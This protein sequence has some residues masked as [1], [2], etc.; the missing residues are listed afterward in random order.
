MKTTSKTVNFWPSVADLFLCSFLLFLGLSVTFHLPVFLNYQKALAVGGGH[1]AEVVRLKEENAKLKAEN[2]KLKQQVE[3]DKRERERLF[4]NI[5]QHVFREQELKQRLQELLTQL[6][7]SEEDVRKLKTELADLR[8]AHELRLRE[9]LRQL[10]KKEED[11]LKLNMELADRVEELRLAKALLAETLKNASDAK[12]KFEGEEAQTKGQLAKVQ[13]NAE[14]ARKKFEDEERRLKEL[15]AEALK[16]SEEARK[17]F[18]REGNPTPAII[19][20]TDKAEADSGD[21]FGGFTFKSGSATLSPDFLDQMEGHHIMDKIIQGIAL[22]KS[23]IIE[24][25]GHT[26]VE[27]IH[28]EQHSEVAVNLDWK[29][30]DYIENP[31]LIPLKLPGQ[32]LPGVGS[33]MDLGMLRAI[34]VKGEVKGRVQ[35][36]LDQLDNNPLLAAEHLKKAMTC[37]QNPNPGQPDLDAVIGVLKRLQFRLYSAG[38]A[39]LPLNKNYEHVTKTGPRNPAWHQAPISSDRQ[40][41]GIPLKD[42]RRRRIEIRFAQ[43]QYVQ[44]PAKGGE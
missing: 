32:H 17:K 1:L 31:A 15:L 7:K 34:A 26:D 4:E 2:E 13:G 42:G 36:M 35:E 11:V 24:I 23:D 30:G 12:K 20:L 10:A 38:P 19:F 16:N 39:I 27:S 37:P 6:A 41:A 3:V 21:E 29:L 8:A 44:Q 33:N 25:M 40:P 22:Y 5:T 28:G 18:E 43:R 9:L 14:E